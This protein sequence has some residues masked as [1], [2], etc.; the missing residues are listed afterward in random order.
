[1]HTPRIM[2]LHGWIDHDSQMTP[3]DFEVTRSKV[4]VTP[5]EDSFL[6]IVRERTETEVEDLSTHYALMNVNRVVQF[7]MNPSEEVG[8]PYPAAPRGSDNIPIVYLPA[9]TTKLQFLARYIAACEERSVRRLKISSFKS[10]FRT[11][12]LPNRDR[13]F[14]ARASDFASTLSAL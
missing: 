3:V 9:S 2:K 6:R 4:K 8:L 7:I 11:L 14:V 1:M 10:I 5:S 13:T 12:E